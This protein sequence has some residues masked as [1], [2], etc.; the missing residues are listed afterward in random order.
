[1][2]LFVMTG[3][4]VSAGTFISLVFGLIDVYLPD[5]LVS[6]YDPASG[7]RWSLA[8]LTV[9]FP[10]YLWG[11]W[12]LH[13][14]M[15]ANGWK[16]D[17]RIRKWLVH[18]TLFAAAALVIGDLISL[19]YNFLQG[20]LSDRFLLKTLAVF[21]VGAAVF[22]Y[23]L[24]DLRRR[25]EEF[26]LAMKVFMT[27]TV[28]VVAAVIITG[29]VMAGSPF[30]ERLARFD[31]QKISHLQSLQGQVVFFWQ[32]K[33]RLPASLDELR[34]PISGFVPPRDPQSGEAY[35][36]RVSGPLS[37]ELCAE[38]NLASRTDQRPRPEPLI[39]PG[40]PAN[41]DHGE[42]SACFGRTIDPE[43][44]GRRDEIKQ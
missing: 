10:V 19:L 7:V 5:P 43:L 18:I 28:A 26:S 17:L 32:Q 8:T 34:D 39:Y 27:A 16:A 22:I 41:W 44:Y 29:F 37:F 1:M 6:Y 23:Y 24:Y 36:Y 38:F 30:R 4:Y 2:H 9:I 31:E 33:Q 12:F 40:A 11:S 15:A 42:G 13:K 20:G 14:D 3:L 25:P 21:A 35:E